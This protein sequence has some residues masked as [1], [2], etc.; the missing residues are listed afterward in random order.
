MKKNLISSRWSGFTMIELLVVTTIII[1]L[2][3]IALVSYSRANMSAR[4]GKR[5]ADLETLRQALV[6]YRTDTGAYP[7]TA[8]FDAMVGDLAGYVSS[9]TFTDPKNDGVYIY[10]YNSA[11]GVTFTLGAK[12]EPDADDYQL[13]NP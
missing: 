5:K 12:L 9:S 2:S 1:L 3:T 11:T 7:I 6:L 4:N 13:T 10:T 8:N